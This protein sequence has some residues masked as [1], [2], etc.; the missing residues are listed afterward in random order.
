MRLR[1]LRLAL[2][3]A[4]L[5]WAI[6]VVGVFLPWST[7]VA[8]L[9]ELGA[10]E[11]PNDPMLQYWFRMTAGGF[12]LIGL[13]FFALAGRPRTYASAL[14]IA[15]GLMLFE[16][17]VLLAHGLLLGLPGLPFCADV[18][19]CFATGLAIFLLRSSANTPECDAT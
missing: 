2:I 13:F 4:G 9:K 1:L 8:A 5:G 3:L 10:T 14:P 11:I 15:G 17:M 7:A 16:G 6:A 18:A 19:F 12:T